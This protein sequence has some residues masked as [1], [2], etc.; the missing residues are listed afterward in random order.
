MESTKRPYR[1]ID[2]ERWECN[3]TLGE[4]IFVI[5]MTILVFAV[6]GFCFNASPEKSQRL[7]DPDVKREI[8]YKLEHHQPEPLPLNTTVE[9]TEPGYRYEWEGQWV[10]L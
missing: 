6:L 7:I 3:P 5:I 9:I 10:R 2:I 1:D 8:I 4:K